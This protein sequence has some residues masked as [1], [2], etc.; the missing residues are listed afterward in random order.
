[1]LDGKIPFDGPVRL[2]HGTADAAVPWEISLH[3]QQALTSTDVEV[4]LIK[5]GDHRLSEPADLARLTRV[6]ESVLER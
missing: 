3:I 1:M 6:V 4:T 2:L 5:D